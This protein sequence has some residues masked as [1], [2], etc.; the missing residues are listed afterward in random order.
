VQLNDHIY[1]RKNIDKSGC[2]IKNIGVRIFKIR[3]RSLLKPPGGLSFSKYHI[4]LVQNFDLETLKPH[5]P[6]LMIPVPIFC[7]IL[8]LVLNPVLWIL[9]NYYKMGLPSI[10]AAAD[11]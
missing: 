5:G 2:K 9:A 7:F 6:I 11:Y 1:S 8:H 3:S 10:Q 4:I